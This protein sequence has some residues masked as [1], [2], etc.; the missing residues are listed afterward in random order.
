[1]AA[2]AAK[3]ARDLDGRTPLLLS[4]IV[5]RPSAPA[6][7]TPLCLLRAGAFA[8]AAD[9]QG[10]TALDIAVRYGRGE[11]V[12]EIFSRREGAPRPIPGTLGLLYEAV[13]GGDAG[14]VACLVDNGWEGG[15]PVVAAS[16]QPPPPPPP[17]AV[18]PSLESRETS[19]APVPSPVG[20]KGATASSP[21]AE[22]AAGSPASVVAAAAGETLSPLMLAADSGRVDVVR[23]LLRGRHGG[24]PNAGDTRGYTALHFATV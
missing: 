16:P 17:A 3:E 14:I 9:A 4:C 22:A 12:R 19:G 20:R 21:A 23:A 2:G 8:T 13:R 5:Q 1:M 18:P 6:I 24:F 7:T 10:T 15:V 11:I